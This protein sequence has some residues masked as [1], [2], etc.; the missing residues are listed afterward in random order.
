[1]GGEHFSCSQCEAD[2]EVYSR[3]VGYMS[4]VRQWNEGK[5]QE[6]FDRKIFKVKQHTRVKQIV[7]QKIN[8]NDECI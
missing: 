4:P 5:Q 6:F 1:M 2:Y 8:E 7:L 3:I